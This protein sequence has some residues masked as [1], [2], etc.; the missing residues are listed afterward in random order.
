MFSKFILWHVLEF[1]SFL[2]LSNIQLCG[3]T[4]FCLSIHLLID[5]WV[6]TTFWLL[7]IMQIWTLF[8]NDPFESLYFK[9]IAKNE[10]AGSYGN[11]ILNF[12]HNHYTVFHSCCSIFRSHQQY[13]RVPVSPHPYQCLLFFLFSFLVIAILMPVK[14]YVIV[15]WFAFPSCLV[16]VEHIFKY[17]LAICI[18]SLG[19][20][21]SNSFLNFELSCSAFVEL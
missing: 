18:S 21:L 2:W 12:L 8:C 20:Y 11:S 7:W 15:F 14:C 4:T 13:V 10:I 16:I 19:K 17:I 9:Y 1:H 6:V 5:I 3:H